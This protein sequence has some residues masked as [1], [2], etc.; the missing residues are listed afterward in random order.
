M[1]ITIINILSLL[2]GLHHVTT[3][4]LG[5]RK[6]ALVSGEPHRRLSGASPLPLACALFLLRAVCL[7]FWNSTFITLNPHFHISYPPCL[8]SVVR[9]APRR[10]TL[11]HN[12]PS[13]SKMTSPS[14]E[15][16]WSVMGLACKKVC[17]HGGWW[18]A[19]IRSVPI[20][21]ET[22]QGGCSREHLTLL[23]KIES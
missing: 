9:N 4:N 14:N 18:A 3:G 21:S 19:R 1:A 10:E 6:S 11:W 17:G 8:S 16:D 12:S 2:R 7:D 20:L 23:A 22:M 13:T 5:W 15:T